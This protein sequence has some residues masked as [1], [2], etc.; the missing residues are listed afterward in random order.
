MKRKGIDDEYC[1]KMILDYLCRFGVGTRYDFER[2]LLDK[3]SDHLTRAQKRNKIKNLL[4]GLKKDNRIELR[5]SRQWA[6]KKLIKT[7][8]L[9]ENT[10]SL[11]VL[12]D[13]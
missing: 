11:D 9:D 4:Q 1:R 3:L 8:V 2:L 5:D 6:Q 13:K 7:D 12:D 10:L